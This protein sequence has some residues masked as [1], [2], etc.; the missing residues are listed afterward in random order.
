MCSCLTASRDSAAAAYRP[1]RAIEGSQS[2]VSGHLH[3]RAAKAGKL[4]R[5]QVLVGV[6]QLA[7]STVAHLDG[8]LGRPD[9]VGEQDCHQDS[10][11]PHMIPNAG[12]ELFDLVEDG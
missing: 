1:S 11:A 10:V 8:C 9:D 2:P 6:Q 3:L 12:E 5:H 7:P 4:S